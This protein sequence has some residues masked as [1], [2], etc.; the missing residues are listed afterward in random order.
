[1]TNKKASIMKLQSLTINKWRLGLIL[2]IPVQIILFNIL[3]RNHYQIESIYSQHIYKGIVFVLRSLFGWIP[4]P[5]AQILIFV[6]IT[7]VIIWLVKQSIQIRRK[8]LG[9]VKFL[10][11]AITLGLAIFS[12][13][14]FLFMTLWGFNYHRQPVSEI[15][16]INPS[17]I[18]AAE[19]ENVCQKLIQLTNESRK[20]VTSDEI[21]SLVLPMSNHQIIEKAITG[22]EEIAK[23]YPKLRYKVRS[24]KPVYIPQLMSMVGVGGIYIP[25]TGEAIVNMDPPSYLLPA[26]VCH[27][28]AHQLGFSPEDEANYV[29]FLVCRSNPDPSFQYSGYFMAMRYAM[30]A[31]GGAN[32]EAFLLLR[33]NISK[34]VMADIEANRMYWNRFYNPISTFTSFF[35][36]YFLKANGQKEGIRSYSLMIKLIVGE[37]RKDGLVNSVVK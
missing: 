21:H 2:F 36:D 37:Y 10:W 13:F 32:K 17:N 4:L 30:N 31:L 14:Y 34:G 15:V 8:K 12:V 22:Y 16:Q 11:N 5:V 27:E 29:S 19:L 26:T 20:L 25:F 35:Y 9:F 7:I 23:T 1:M 6:L 28:M 18:T 3:V 33:K 24:V